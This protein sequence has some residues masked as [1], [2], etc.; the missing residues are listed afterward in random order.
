MSNPNTRMPR[1]AKLVV[2]IGALA[3][4]ATSKAADAELRGTGEMEVAAGDVV[5]LAVTIDPLARSHMVA[6]EGSLYLQIQ[7]VSASLIPDDPEAPVGMLPTWSYSDP[8]RPCED[9]GACVVRYT[10]EV[11]AGGLLT[12]DAVATAAGD[13]EFPLEA[14][15]YVTLE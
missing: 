5:R 13:W 7:G 15:I 12:V 8:L 1:L 3:T 9:E 2:V 4:I 11:D 14:Q 10:I 6:N